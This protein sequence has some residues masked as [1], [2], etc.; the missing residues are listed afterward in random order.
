MATKPPRPMSHDLMLY[1]LTA[2]G[3]P[4][5]KKSAIE[6]IIDSTFYAKDS[7]LRRG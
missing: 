5:L 6:E 2:M 4:L 7:Q 3:A 1:M